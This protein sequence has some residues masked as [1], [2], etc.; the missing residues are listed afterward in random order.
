MGLR[1]EMQRI[2][3]I[4]ISLPEPGFEPGS[5]A[6]QSSTLPLDQLGSVSARVTYNI[7]STLSEKYI[8]SLKNG[9]CCVNSLHIK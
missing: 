6:C 3:E 5:S 1:A 7:L 2:F 4:K 9:N 8:S